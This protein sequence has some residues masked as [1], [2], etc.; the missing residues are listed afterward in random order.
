[1]CVCARVY[2]GMLCLQLNDFLPQLH[3]A[4]APVNAA[5]D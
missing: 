1:M 3:T 4:T 5:V 2:T